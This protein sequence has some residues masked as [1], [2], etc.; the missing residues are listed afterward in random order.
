MI[1][2]NN[3]QS[4]F[5]SVNK[6][7]IC[8]GGIIALS[9]SYN[10]IFGM[11]SQIS[12]IIV[13]ER[14]KQLKTDSLT[15]ETGSVISTNHSESTEHTELSDFTDSIDSVETTDTADATD[16][17]SDKY[18]H[19]YRDFSRKPK[20]YIRPKKNHTKNV[21]GNRECFNYTGGTISEFNK[22]SPFI[23][24][25]VNRRIRVC[26]NGP[27]CHI[28]AFVQDLGMENKF[29]GW[30][31]GKLAIGENSER[32][33]FGNDRLSTHAEMDALKKLDGLIRVQ[34]CKKQK[35]DLVV[36]R[37]NK[38]GNLCESA[39]CYH[40]TKELEKTKVVSINKLY[41]SRSDGTITCV[42]F[43]EWL[44]NEH[45]HVSKGWRWMNCVSK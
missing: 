25:L 43:S 17:S 3:Q 26:E 41:F 24:M 34:K 20:K 6:S 11:E 22:D 30:A 23:N 21:S 44:K 27:S 40:C 33:R 13:D 18:A 45:L 19:S 9:K 16:S 1:V 14:D 38:S 12:D 7:R 36:I 37:V 8:N 31:F 15:D 39:P 29:M 35:M 28:A 5:K 42:K 32:M 2:S 10:S 4:R